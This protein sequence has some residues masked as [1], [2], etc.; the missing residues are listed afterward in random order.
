MLMKSSCRN[1]LCVVVLT[2]LGCSDDQPSASDMLST[3]RME[4]YM[5]KSI[6]VTAVG[7]EKD[8]VLKRALRT[9]AIEK[10][11][12]AKAQGEPG[13]VCDFRLSFRNQRGETEFGPQS[14]ARF[15]KAGSDWRIAQAR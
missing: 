5:G 8:D 10:A 3:I 11:G 6:L 13:Y 2:L 4:E 12:C 14:K 1:A 7:P 15:F 9:A